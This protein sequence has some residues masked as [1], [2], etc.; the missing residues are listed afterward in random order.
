MRISELLARGTPT[1]SFEFF[2][3][4]TDVGRA[5]LLRVI[6]RLSQI[7]PDFVSV[8]YGAGGS[9]RTLSL[10]SCS[11][12]KSVVDGEV[13]AHLT[14]LCHTADDIAAITDHLWESGIVNIMALRGD[15]PKD[16]DPEAV[17]HGFPHAQEMMAYIKTRHDFCLGGAC[18]PE[19]HKE[20]P[21]ISTGVEH[22]REKID[23]GCEFL[24]TQMFFD[25]DA[26]LRFMDL[27]RAAGIDVPVIPGI[28][29]ISGF[30]QLDKFENQFG[31]R[32]PTELRNRV[33]AN[34][35]DQE[36]IEQVGIDWSAEQCRTLLAGGAPGIHFYTLN[37]SASTVKVC[38]AMGLA[39]AVGNPEA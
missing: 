33:L 16:L 3:P 26:Y 36:A 14:G 31:V 15:R 20:T 12:V 22:L 11:E 17:L 1:V 28:M 9:A 32:L 5:S 4:K 6:E 18:Y 29:P 2:P 34:E 27:V 24:V 38:L 13:M 7:G 35:G 21:D 37:K 30:A 23:S 39:G 10:D 8:T 25:N 19:G